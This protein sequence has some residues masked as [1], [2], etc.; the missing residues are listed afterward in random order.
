MTI[1]LNFHCYEKREEKKSKAKIRQTHQLSQTR[2]KWQAPIKKI[3][4][5]LR[6]KIKRNIIISSG[7]FP[8]LQ[9]K[10]LLYPQGHSLL[11]QKSQKSKE[12]NL[13]W[14]ATH[15]PSENF[16]FVFHLLQLS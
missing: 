6:R 4:R 10:D 12:Q 3:P 13:G 15:F 1:Q 8:F 14:I 7:N 5:I 2:F 16:I 11:F 9:W